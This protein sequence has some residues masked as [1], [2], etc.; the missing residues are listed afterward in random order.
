M[1]AQLRYE[2]AADKHLLD[3]L[4]ICVVRFQIL[5]GGKCLRKCRVKYNLFIP[6]TKV[7]P[8]VPSEELLLQFQ[9]DEPA[10]KPKR[11]RPAIRTNKTS[12]GLH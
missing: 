6:A 1:G 7:N 10:E 11:M 8:F 3:F 4:F 9:S 5:V 2:S 12:G